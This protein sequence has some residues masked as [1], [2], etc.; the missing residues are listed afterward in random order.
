[1][2]SRPDVALAV[3]LG[4]VNAPNSIP[5]DR[6]VAALEYFEV[7]RYLVRLIRAYLDDRWVVY[8]SREE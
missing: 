6:I 5:W 3:F 8:N 2:V 1:M 4:I 7:L